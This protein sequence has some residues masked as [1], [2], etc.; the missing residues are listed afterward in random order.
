MFVGH[1]G[2]ALAL[3]PAKGSPSLPVLFTAV[4]LVDIAFFSFLIP[5]VERMRITPGATVMNAMDL[6]FLPYTHSLVGALGFSLVFGAIVA[7][8]TPGDIRWRAFAI[9]AFAVFSH[10]LLD[11]L[12]HRPDLGLLGDSEVKLGFGL[13]N[14]PFVEIPLEIAVALIG[15]AIFLGSRRPLSRT[16]MLSI[17]VL[18][19]AM[20]G[21][22]AFNWFGP[23]P[24]AGADLTVFAIEGV[25]AYLIFIALAWWVERTT[26]PGHRRRP[27]RYADGARPL[28]A[29]I[30]AAVGVTRRPQPP[31]GA[32]VSQPMQLKVASYNIRK[33]VGLD[34]RRRPARVLDV[35]N[36]IG[37]DIVALQEVD[38]RFGSRISALDPG[39]HRKAHRLPGH[40]LLA[41]ARR[42][43]ATMATS[44]SPARR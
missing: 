19:V 32:S 42:A 11:L 41:D 14:Y 17:G 5:G 28:I 8:L 18:V 4:Q 39:T 7:A 27:R 31:P 44:S 26:A 43:S 22:Q 34:W 1:Y 6:Y 13:W 15:L 40:P 3:R 12:V 29:V 24:A 38:R 20:A 33:A 30:Q 10:W 25:V 36:E 9:S 37:A 2:V 23:S 16:A 21:L 35:L